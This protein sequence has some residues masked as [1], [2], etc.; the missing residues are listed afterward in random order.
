[1][2]PRINIESLENRVLLAAA[3]PIQMID[4]MPI[5]TI[6]WRGEQAQMFAGRWVVKLSGYD[7]YF[8]D[9]QDRFA[10]VLTQQHRSFSVITH[11]AADGMFLVR[12]PETMPVKDAVAELSALPGFI[13]VEPDFRY[14]LALTPNDTDFGLL[15]GLNNTGQS[16]GTVDADVD[17]PEGWNTS[18][19]SNTVVV[20]MVDTG[21]DYNHPDLNDNIWINTLEIAGNTIDD[22][23]NGFVDDI[24]GWDFWSNDS[25]S[26]D[27]NSASHGTHTAG[28][29]GA[30]GNNGTGVVG[31]NWNVK[32]IGMKI[33]STGSSVSGAAAVSSMNYLLN[34]KN[35]VNQ[36]PNIKATNHSWGGGGF[37]GNMN[38]AIEN[39][40]AAGIMTVC[41]AGNNG[42]NIEPTTTSFYPAEY[43][44]PNNIAV[45]NLTRFNAR[46]TGSN[47]GAT[48]VDLF[49]PGT[50][51]RSTTRVAAG[52]YGSLTGT[53]MAAPHVAGAVALLAAV[54]PGATYQQIK[55]AI[56]QG[57]ETVALLAG[58][59]LTGGRLDLDGA[60]NGLAQVPSAP[61]QPDLFSG[62]DL[63][64]FNND[65]VT[66]D[67]T[68]TFAGTGA[69]A[70]HT[71]RIFSDAVQV[72]SGVVDGSGN[73]SV[74]TSALAHGVRQI[75]ARAFNGTAESGPSTALSVTIDTIA[76]TA[77]SPAFNFLTSP[78]SVGVVFSENVGWSV[79]NGDFTVDNLTNP[80]S[81]ALSAV[82]DGGANSVSMSFPGNAVLPDARFRM[83]VLGTGGGV[84]DVA[85]NTMAANF[86][87]DF[88]FLNGDANR[89]ERVNLL[90]FD[91]VAANFGQSGRNF[92]QGNFTYDVAGNVN[93]LDFDVLAS[94]FGDVL[95]AA[96]TSPFG[97]DPIKQTDRVDDPLQ[98]LLA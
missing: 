94:R 80:G 17:A 19:G 72:G 81:V 12:G 2:H 40:A 97:N 77:G 44:Q 41:A 11:M 67:N 62:S 14:E 87:Y 59:C 65:N 88:F 5:A 46:N 71:I 37:D 39:H 7:G 34:L 24:R 42:Q 85:G 98:E 95:A 83:T 78:H 70:G 38:T 26:M 1:M 82:Y 89:D 73:W 49:A 92:T 6:T 60:I 55:T 21:I 13:S 36:P 96:R 52:S 90:D 48:A 25:D 54:A 29:V 47:Y 28:T 20:G 16:G 64:Q 57:V 75:T 86:V 30:E 51:I 22:D 45:G 79:A 58:F 93:L 35:R 3:P 63:G 31:V 10:Q 66:S 18:T 68:P 4:D 8:L 53:S 9:Q 61:A 50:D 74:T 69:T 27:V 43:N 76:P 56:F 33:G 84:Q 32:L 23:G 91:I 15:W